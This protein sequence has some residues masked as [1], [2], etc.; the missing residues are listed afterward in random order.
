[1]FERYTEPAR[2]V[3]FFARYEA[4]QFGS[5]S[6]E[7]EH[8][9]LGLLREGKGLACR[10]LARAGLSPEAVRAEIGR[11]TTPRRVVSTSVEIPFS[12]E[13]KQALQFAAE[14]SD[15]LLHDYIGAE[16]LLLGMLRMDGSLAASIL[17][18]KG[19]HLSAVREDIVQLHSAREMSEDSAAPATRPLPA[20]TGTVP[21]F[22][23]SRVV[24]IMYSER[25]PSVRT[26]EREWIAL[27][28]PLKR[29]IAAAWHVDEARIEIP[30]ALG[31]AR[32][33][34]VATLPREESRAAIEALV[35]HAIE[36][37]FGITV[38]L[39]PHGTDVFVMTAPAGP[40]RALRQRSDPIGAGAAAA[41][42]SF[43]T[44]GAY[45]RGRPLFPMDSL[46]L[47]G[48]SLSMLCTT[49]A[50]IIGAPVIDQSGLRGR[51]D[52]ELERTIGDRDALLAALRD[53][54]G[55]TLTLEHRQIDRL[56]VRP[57]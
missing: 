23:P 24:H 44:T 36:D 38:T 49:V 42:V 19:M 27:G 11:R 22:L 31:D 4:S 37:Q 10:L 26:S 18:A 7:L 12:A 54:A 16:H 33:D 28:H 5:Q 41:S 1:M 47:S 51:F 21:N 3:L 25:H 57:R 40:G 20:S 15:R 39:E 56:V 34:V 6:M 2:R 50:E 43:S 30:P 29:A 55:L 53:E 45:E 9:L 35:R 52:L 13:F 46:V 32:F 48:V 17:I 14:E 8:L